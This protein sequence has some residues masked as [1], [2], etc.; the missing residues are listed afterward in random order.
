MIP[1]PVGWGD[2]PDEIPSELGPFSSTLP[3]RAT[4]VDGSNRDIAASLVPATDAKTEPGCN[5]ALAP[6]TKVSSSVFSNGDVLSSDPVFKSNDSLNA[7]ATT[8]TTKLSSRTR[9]KGPP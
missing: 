1:R 4:C 2:I 7:T 5:D 6:P 9:E 3:E 8:V